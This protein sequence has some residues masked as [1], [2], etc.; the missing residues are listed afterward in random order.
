MPW[1]ETSHGRFER[2][3]NSLESV[4]TAISNGG[5]AL[6]R[7]HYAISA[8]VFFRC[9]TAACDIE[10]SLRHAWKTMCY[11]YPQIAAYAQGDTYVYEIPD[12][13]SLSSWLAETFI[14]VPE[15]TMTASELFAGFTPKALAMMYYLPHKS[16]VLLH[17]SHFRIDGIGALHFFHRFFQA[18]AEPRTVGFGDE[19]KNLLPGLDEV[20]NLSADITPEV[21]Q[22]AAD[23]LAEYISSVPSIGLPTNTNQ[24]PG[25]SRRCSI[26][27]TLQQ[28]SIILSGCKA[29]GISVTTAVHAAVIGVTQQE[30]DPRNP[31]K[32]YAAFTAFDLRR[33]CPPPYNGAD[34][35]VSIFHTGM[36]IVVTPSTFLGTAK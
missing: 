26:E 22:V 33:Y 12:A 35:P 25:A 18:L 16:E 9:D 3:F 36:P 28:T 4:F 14:V 32:K 1:K 17:S 8:A 15:T 23:R 20:L 13:A 11:D 24:V 29:H 10:Q 30:A 7:E 2:P 31:A 5:I 34:N 6:N 19:D 21:E 27:L